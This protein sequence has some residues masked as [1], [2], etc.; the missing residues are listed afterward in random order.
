MKQTHLNF[1]QKEAIETIL[2]NRNVE[3]IRSNNKNKEIL[4]LLTYLH[5]EYLN[6]KIFALTKQTESLNKQLLI[7]VKVD[8]TAVQ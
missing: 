8:R 7:V 6:P 2:V 4:I 3:I 5:L 1:P